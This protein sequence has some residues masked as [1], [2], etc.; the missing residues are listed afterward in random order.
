MSQIIEELKK[1]DGL[2]RVRQ[3]SDYKIFVECKI[4]IFCSDGNS[5]KVI[6]TFKLK[7]RYR[8]DKNERRSSNEMPVYYLIPIKDR[9]LQILS[10]K[11]KIKKKNI[12]LQKNFGLKPIDGYLVSGIYSG[13]I[14]EDKSWYRDYTLKSI[15]NET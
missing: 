15:L 10:Q 9:F 1:E 13:I 6:D 5:L 14:F 4:P 3:L 2:Y 8:I 11:W 12:L 7:M